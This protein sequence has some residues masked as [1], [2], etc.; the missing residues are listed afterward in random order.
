MNQNKYQTNTRKRLPGRPRRSREEDH[1]NTEQAILYHAG[2][3]F[4]KSGYAAVSI[5]SITKEVGITKPTLYH[6]FPDKEHLY[7]AVLCNQLEQAGLEILKSIQQDGTVRERLF[8]IAYGFFC[9]VSM[10]TSVWMRDVGEQLSTDLIAQVHQTYDKEIVAPIINLMQEGME[11][12]EIRRQSDDV[13]LLVD[14][15]FGFLD[16][17]AQKGFQD[18]YDDDQ[19]YRMSQLV[20]TIFFDGVSNK[21]CDHV[22]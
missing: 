22:D 15:W 9:F 20:T 16:A 7:T 6:Y 5:S 18:G 19:V 17:L 8:R 2:Q 13:R 10:S 12:R 3:L 1:Y 11:N 14:I 4:M 21:R